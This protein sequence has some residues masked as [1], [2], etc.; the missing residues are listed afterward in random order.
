MHL[1]R[2]D[3]LGGR[4]ARE[5][6]HGRSNLGGGRFFKRCR[7]KRTAFDH[8]SRVGPRARRAIWRC[9]IVARQHKSHTRA[10]TARIA[11][12]RRRHC[13]FGL[14][15]VVTENIPCERLEGPGPHAR[16]AAA[17][18]VGAVQ[19]GSAETLVAPHLPLGF[20]VDH[21]VFWRLEA[22]RRELQHV[23]H[24]QRSPRALPHLPLQGS[25]ALCCGELP[26]EHRQ[27][28]TALPRPL[29]VLGRDGGGG[30]GRPAELAAIVRCEGRGQEPS[31]A[32]G[33]QER[34]GETAADPAGEHPARPRRSPVYLGKEAVERAHKRLGGRSAQ[35]ENIFDARLL[36]RCGGA[37]RS[38]FTKKEGG[39][40]DRGLL[41]KIISA[42][43]HDG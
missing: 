9:P 27:R 29:R 3:G 13:H 41:G 2:L 38:E 5:P 18:V 19:R 22:F 17:A 10:V 7:P 40:G 16:R 35:G 21:V 4:I 25:N 12:D 37:R 36:G 20:V 32:A 23:F 30:A 34:Q 39:R 1:F 6:E 28:R 8:N 15:L 14:G 11:D 31:E 24:G 42:R 33:P 26:Q 43:F